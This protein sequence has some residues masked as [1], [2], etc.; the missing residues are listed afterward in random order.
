V[1]SLS[2]PH[3]YDAAGRDTLLTYR[4]LKV[5]AGLANTY[6][7]D[8]VDRLTLQSPQGAAPT[9]Y[10]WDPAGNLVS[11]TFAGGINTYT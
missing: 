10:G 7:F 8:S 11:A 6:Q 4:T 3:H 5:D 1:T 2:Y 9:T